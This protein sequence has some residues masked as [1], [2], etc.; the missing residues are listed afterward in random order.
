MLQTTAAVVLSLTLTAL[1]APTEPI[2]LYDLTPQLK[3]DP[4][5]PQAVAAAWEHI[6]AVT[7]L[8]GIVNRD[9]PRLYVRF[10]EAHG[11]NLDDH[12]LKLYSKP[13]A[14]LA[15]RKVEAVKSLEALI[16][17]YRSYISGVVVYDPRVPATSN[18]ASTL[19]GAE[20]LIAVRFNPRPGSVYSRLV[21]GGPRLPV[22][23]SLV[24]LDRN[25]ASLFTGTGLIPGT[26]QPS[27]GSAKCDAYLW[28]KHHYIDTGKASAAFAG[29]Y[30][31]AFWLTN[32]TARMAYGHMLPN[33]DWFVSKRAW[34]MDLDVWDDEAPVD[35]PSQR[36]GTD[37]KTLRTLLRASYD[38]AGPQTMIHVG[39]FPAW[40]L[41]YTN[42]DKSGGKHD[43]VLTEW[44]YVKL[45]SAY[46]AFCDADAGHLGVMAN[47]SFWQH[48]PT[49]DQYKQ[50][51]ID[52]E[53]LQKRGYLT[54][55]GRVNFAGRDFFIFYVGDFDSAAWLYQL[56]PSLWDHPARGK[57]PLMWAIDPELDRRVPHI[58]H[59]LRQTASPNDY[60][61]AADS[62]AGYVNVGM[63]SEPRAISGLPSGVEAWRKQCQY[64]YHKW[65]LSISGFLIDGL[66]PGPDTQILDA[67]A[68][69]S[70]NGLVAQWVP[71]SLLHGRMPVMKADF[72]LPDDPVKAGAI[73]A[74]RVKVRAL[75]FHWFRAVI[76]TPDWYA[77]VYEQARTLHPQLE[78]LD[79]PTFFE[80]YRRYLEQTP[81]AAAGRIPLLKPASSQP[82]E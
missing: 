4:A 70:P 24:D 66:S 23:R 29:Y 56:M 3:Y 77:K 25:G 65:G 16:D 18:L 34:F 21:K 47:A 54:A 81:D 15:D 76:K 53:Q 75:P 11:R 22:V 74:E 37:Y 2:G 63:L 50:K 7:T 28:L 44:R 58:L 20:N 31:D 48:F 55:E 46:N 73:I 14:W 52:T 45:L 32:P 41:K 33:H 59:Y 13:G 67:Y 40:E 68:S 27:T 26:N 1:G 69:F 57:L 19:A 49:A 38:Q 42:Y 17:R 10:V 80:L 39:G 78:L 64:Y 60:F 51:W 36:L 82:A 43:P 62:G 71:P 9:Q 35:D 61:V 72:D 30:I 8:Q 79:A 12:W 6:H 5:D